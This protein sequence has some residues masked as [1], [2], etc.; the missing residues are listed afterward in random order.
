MAALTG[1][2]AYQDPNEPPPATQQDINYLRAEIQ[3]QRT[4][5]QSLE[6]QLGQINGDIQQDRYNQSSAASS[7]A[8]S[9][10]LSSFQ[11]SVQ[12]QLSGLRQQ[13]AAVDEAR[14]NDRKEIMGSVS[15]IIADA[16]KASAA[17]SSK[18]SG[19]KMP[20]GSYTG[21]EHVVQ[22]GETLSA[23][24]VA[25]G[26]KT[27]TLLEYNNISNPSLIRVGQTLFIPQ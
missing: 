17:S 16:L 25:Y 7:Y 3:R 2:V 5:I 24:A 15:K 4:I 13:I 6:Q 22:S 20:S 11:S 12:E 9:A 18:P 8:S 1:C 10:Q 27:S 23:I 21:I 14:V 26:V 19:K